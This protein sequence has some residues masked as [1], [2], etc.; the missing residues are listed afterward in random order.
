MSIQIFD[1]YQKNEQETKMDNE[2]IVK[3]IKD[4]CKK[5]NIT[6]NQLESEVGLS[7]GLIS[8]WFKT[9]PS[10]DKIIDIADYFHVSLDEVVGYDKNKFNDDFIKILYDKTMNKEIQWQTFNPSVDES[11]IKKYTEISG[12]ELFLSEEEYLD[13]YE[14]HK[15]AVYYFE[16]M[17]GYISIYAMYKYH[18]ITNPEDLKL[19][20]QPDIQAEL[21]KQPFEISELLPL[22]LKVLVSLDEKA[23]DEIKAE[24]LKNRFVNNT[25]TELDKCSDEQLQYITSDILYK[26]PQMELLFETINSPSF[27]A[28]QE[29]FNKPNFKEATD[30]ANRLNKY[31]LMIKEQNK[32]NKKTGD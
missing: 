20:I 11:G 8:R 13:F 14:L 16:Y 15:E 28:L 32:N 30:I 24:E 29:T 12:N 31:Y 19:F 27:K 1:K 3:S 17:H 7:Q 26:D 4:L 10:L 5:N 21:I 23:P 9:M 6:A 18:N 22:W 25:K 2:L